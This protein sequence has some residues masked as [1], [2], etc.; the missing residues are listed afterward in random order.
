MSVE[1]MDVGDDMFESGARALVCPVNCHGI[2]GAG[3]A[4]EFKAR[5]PACFHPYAY[6]CAQRRI[7][8]TR[9]EPPPPDALDLG[10]VKVI[11]LKDVDVVCVPTK[12]HWRLASRMEDV[13][14]GVRALAA[15]VEARAWP[16]LAVPALGCGLG[17]LDWEPVRSLL[18]TT[19][20]HTPTHVLVYPPGR[21]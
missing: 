16:R 14:V 12:D 11:E 5:W 18:E 8:R 7:A 19:F 9:D 6:A 20:A 10:R 4:A 17:G 15:E 3:L 13:V 2:M 1:V 21:S